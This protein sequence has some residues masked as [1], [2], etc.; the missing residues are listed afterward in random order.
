[1]AADGL[2]YVDG[3]DPDPWPA[4][5]DDVGTTH[6]ELCDT[7]LLNSEHRAISTTLPFPISCILL[8]TG[9]I[10][11]LQHLVYFTTSVDAYYY[12]P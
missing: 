9:L 1:M 3:R 10:N 7:A 12:D 11:A 5:A 2:R 6:W 8:N 4:S